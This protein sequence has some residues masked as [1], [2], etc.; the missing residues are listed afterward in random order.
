MS[1]QD[2]SDQSGG[3]EGQRP[4]RLASANQAGR[5]M[6]TGNSGLP[7]EA[8]DQSFHGTDVHTAGAR[9]A[10]RLPADAVMTPASELT[11]AQGGTKVED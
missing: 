11:P 5:E 10:D 6:T 7:S 1:A 3:T 2:N 4:D 8:D 9:A